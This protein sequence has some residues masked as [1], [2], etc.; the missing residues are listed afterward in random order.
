MSKPDSQDFPKLKIWK[1]KSKQ[2][3]IQ[4]SIRDNSNMKLLVMKY[5]S[6]RKC[7]NMNI[8]PGKETKFYNN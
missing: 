4:L 8:K 5:T 1:T 6:N 7:N 2:K 3:W